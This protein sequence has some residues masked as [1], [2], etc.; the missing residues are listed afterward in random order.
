MRDADT[1]SRPSGRD[2]SVDV[3]SRAVIIFTWRRENTRGTWNAR[4]L[5]FCHDCRRRRQRNALR[6]RLSHSDRSPEL[7]TRERNPKSLIR[8]DM[9][10]S[11]RIHSMSTSIFRGTTPRY[12]RVPR[13]FLSV[14]TS[15][16]APLFLQTRRERVGPVNGAVAGVNLESARFKFT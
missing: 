14:Q 2:R 12:T 4:F 7:I 5:R 13:S 3:L 9:L 6:A 10:R 8:G 11:R 1:D 15:N 16:R